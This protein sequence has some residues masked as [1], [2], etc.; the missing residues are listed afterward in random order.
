MSWLR[1]K[2]GRLL[3]HLWDRRELLEQ[4]WWQQ[5]HDRRDAAA[6]KLQAVVH[7]VWTRRR[8]RADAAAVQLQKVRPACTTTHS[9]CLAPLP[10]SVD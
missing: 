9:A 1:C 5:Y 2:P 6:A 3:Q 4:Q 7:G 10:C 8:L